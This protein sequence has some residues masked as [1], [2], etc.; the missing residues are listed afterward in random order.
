MKYKHFKSR[1]DERFNIIN[2]GM[3]EYYIPKD[4]I[5]RTY[6]EHVDI[7]WLC[8]GYLADLKRG[9]T[10]KKCGWTC[11]YSRKY[12]KKKFMKLVLSK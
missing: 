4:C 6:R 7:L 8:W 1:L 9:V 3:Y 5:F 12:N 2:E 11:E 10:N